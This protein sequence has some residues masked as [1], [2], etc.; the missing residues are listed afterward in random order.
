MLFAYSQVFFDDRLIIS[1]IAFAHLVDIFATS[2]K[3]SR[4]RSALRIDRRFR[5]RRRKTFHAYIKNH[6]DFLRA[7]DRVTYEKT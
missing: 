5:F 6:P 2:R 4:F 1:E 7:G 3:R